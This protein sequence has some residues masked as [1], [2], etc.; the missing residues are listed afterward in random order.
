MSACLIEGEETLSSEQ[1]HFIKATIDRAVGFFAEHFG[2]V[3]RPLVLRVHDTQRSLRTGY[4]VKGD[5]INFPP[6]DRGNRPALDSPDILVH[7]AFHALV[8]QAYPHLMES[9]H[10]NEPEFVRLH[11]GLADYFTHLLYPDREFAEGLGPGGK[12]LRVFRNHRRVSLSPGGHSQGNAITS[13]LL[14]HKVSPEQVR[15][16]LQGAEFSLE[17]M[18]H[19]SPELQRSLRHDAS[20]SLTDTVSNYPASTL[21]KYRLNPG[22]P[23]EIAFEPNESLQRSH[24][25]LQIEWLRPSGMPS[26][27]FTFQEVESHRFSVSAEPGAG[28]EKV[29]AVFRDGEEIIGSRPFYFG[30]A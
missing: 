26:Q 22:T 14:Q 23:L 24:P 28:A 1:R 9:R 17:A 12:P 4:S 27:T 8:A 11:E 3:K 15:G 10:V 29:I 18:G 30:T 13:Y 16:F 21:R 20:M 2:E 5:T 25:D 19:I 7:E 6:D